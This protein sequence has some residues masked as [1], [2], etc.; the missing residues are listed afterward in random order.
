MDFGDILDEWEGQTAKSPGKRGALRDLKRIKKEGGHREDGAPPPEPKKVDPLTAWLRVNGVEDKDAAAEGEELSAGERRRRLLAKKPDAVIDLHGQSRDEA[1]EALE[2]FF[3]SS[4][5]RGCEKVLIIHGKGNHSG[6]S[7]AVLKR[8]VRDFIERCPLA[9]ESG[10]GS[11]A[12][13]GAGSTWV[14]LKGPIVPGR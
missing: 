1:W 9:G 5:R 7:E 8:M 14:L 10:H 2:A 6:G 13:G 11:A 3:H 12:F 4:R